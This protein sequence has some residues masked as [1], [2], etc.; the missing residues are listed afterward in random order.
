L[1]ILKQGGEHI[2]CQ[3]GHKLWIIACGPQITI[4]FMKLYLYLTTR[5]RVCIWPTV[6]AYHGASFWCDFVF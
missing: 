2:Y 1:H 5:D 4:D 3:G 6:P